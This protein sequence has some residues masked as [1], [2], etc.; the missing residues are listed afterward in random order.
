[1]ND[2]PEGQ[3]GKITLFQVR[4]KFIQR[5]FHPHTAHIQFHPRGGNAGQLGFTHCGPRFFFGRGEI[6]RGFTLYFLWLQT[7]A[8]HP[9]LNFNLLIVRGG[10]YAFGLELAHHHALPGLQRSAFRFWFGWAGFTSR[11]LQV[12]LH[13]L[14]LL[15]NWFQLC[16]RFVLFQHSAAQF[17]QLGT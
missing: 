2:A 10:D 4:F 5:V 17:V 11:L 16:Q 13:L 15:K 14:Q 9:H 12:F 7:H 3:A 8:Q 6:R 1:M